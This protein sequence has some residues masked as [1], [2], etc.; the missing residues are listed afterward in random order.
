MLTRIPTSYMWALTK[1]CLPSKSQSCSRMLMSTGLFLFASGYRH[2]RLWMILDALTDR[3][4][5]HPTSDPWCS[6]VERISC[7]AWGLLVQTVLQVLRWSL[8]I[9][10]H[11]I[12]RTTSL[13]IRLHY[14]RT[15]GVVLNSVDLRVGSA[16]DCLGCPSHRHSLRVSHTLITCE[17]WVDWRWATSW[18]GRHV[19]WIYKFTWDEFK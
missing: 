2:G 15:W 14:L 1:L 5:E 12:L 7:D 6:E 17:T 16:Q 11:P 8:F 10:I 18:E 4:H 13:H 9:V 3:V 19:V